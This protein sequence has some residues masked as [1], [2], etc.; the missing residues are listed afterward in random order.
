MNFHIFS[1][2]LV[3]MVF[4]GIMIARV[5]RRQDERF[6]LVDMSGVARGQ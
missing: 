6:G 5:N 4:I 1:S 3:V 2:I